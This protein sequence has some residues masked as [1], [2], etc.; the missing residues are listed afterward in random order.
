MPEQRPKHIAFCG[1]IAVGK[2]TTIRQLSTLLSGVYVAEENVEGNLYLKDFYAEPEHWSFHS[3]ISFLAIR[4]EFY[5]RVPPDTKLVLIDRCLHELITFAKLHFESG[6][7]TERDFVTFSSLH[8][9]L[10]QLTPNLHRIV[11]V[12]CSPETSLARIIK[13][14]R[15]YEE[16]INIEYLDRISSSYEQWLTTR[17][18]NIVR[19]DT[20]QPVDYEKLVTH[21]LS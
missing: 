8:S 13:R 12:H 6:L 21:L 5:N 9:T 2:T 15:E 20:D 11:Y 18:E 1:G 14:G 7:M 19:I 10:A 3:R 4:S 17:N 16:K